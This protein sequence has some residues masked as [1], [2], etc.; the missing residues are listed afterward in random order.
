MNKMIFERERNN[1]LLIA[2][3]TREIGVESSVRLS[4]HISCINHQLQC[5]ANTTK[6]WI[7]IF[8]G[9][10]K[11][12]KILLNFLIESLKENSKNIETRLDYSS[13]HSYF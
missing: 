5:V 13:I 7:E 6:D 11:E 9:F 4:S 8:V 12:R 10:L 2:V 3:M 1:L